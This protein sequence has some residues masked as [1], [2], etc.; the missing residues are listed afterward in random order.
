MIQRLH[1]A[2]WNVNRPVAPSR[3]AAVRTAI[4][5]VGA[6]IIV[7][8]EAHD[9]L[10]P[11]FG[12]RLSLLPGRDGLHRPQRRW[13]TIC[14]HFPLH[15]LPVSDA[16]R[17]VAA[18]F[19]PGGGSVTLFRTVLPWKGSVWR[20]VEPREAFQEALRLLMD[21]VTRLRDAFPEDDVFIVGDFN[22]DLCGGRYAGTAAKAR[23][24]GAHL[25]DAGLLAITAGE[26]DPVRRAAPAYACIDHICISQDARWTVDDIWCW[27]DS[28]APPTGLSDHFGVAADLVLTSPGRRSTT[29]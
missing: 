28:P 16:H 20:D 7:L 5:A 22:Q 24:L 29:G 14:S 25:H 26:N 18:R 23:V 3:L 4:G 9:A 15:P 13:V 6:D 2:N 12:Y 27:P 10:R 17:T 21:D 11:D 8:A 1:L 19:D